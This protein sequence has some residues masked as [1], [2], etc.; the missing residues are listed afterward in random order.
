LKVFNKKPV[1]SSINPASHHSHAIISKDKAKAFTRLDILHNFLIYWRSRIKVSYVVKKNTLVDLWTS[2]RLYRGKP[3]QLFTVN[4]ADEGLSYIGM[5]RQ[6][7]VIGKLDFLRV[8]A[9]RG[10]IRFLKLFRTQKFN[11]DL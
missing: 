1:A 2:L 4:K 3:Q 8:C 7:F 9:R 10:P 5:Q 6:S 11:M